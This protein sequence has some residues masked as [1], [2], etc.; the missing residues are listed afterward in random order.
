MKN[1]L[2]LLLLLGVTFVFTIY[3]RELYIFSD[4]EG[5]TEVKGTDN[6]S[7]SIMT[8]AR[9]SEESITTIMPEDTN[10]DEAEN[11]ESGTSEKITDKASDSKYD[12]EDPIIQNFSENDLYWLSRIIHAEARGESFDGKL[13]VGS[14]VLNRVKNKNYP[15]T[16]YGVIFDKKNGVQ[17][18]PILDG[19]IYNNPSRD[20]INAAKRC[21]EGYRTNKEI[22]FFI[23]PDIATSFWIVNTREYVMTIGNH[24]FYK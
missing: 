24:D 6:T 21:L 8:S 4:T 20:S 13:A 23:N 17:F 12:T 10:N 15:S 19:S 1:I 11:E 5:I 22:L 16:V 7:F 2:N 18:S 9:M 14:V 3:G